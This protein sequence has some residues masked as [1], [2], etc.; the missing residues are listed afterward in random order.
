MTRFSTSLRH[1]ALL[2][3]PIISCAP[4]CELQRWSVDGLTRI[5]IFALEDVRRGEELCYDYQVRRFEE[6]DG[7]EE[8]CYDYQVRGQRAC[9]VHVCVGEARHPEVHSSLRQF[10]TAATTRCGC[11]AATCR[12]YLG[13]N[14]ARDKAG[15]AGGGNAD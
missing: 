7:G 6:G 8:L 4:N 11:G 2:P 14:V 9:C 13:A 15:K 3:P 5:G 1:C 12:G 10:F